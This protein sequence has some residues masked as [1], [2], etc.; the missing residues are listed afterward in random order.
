MSLDASELGNPQITQPGL[1]PEPIALA[2]CRYRRGKWSNHAA[3]R[4]R[5][6]LPA[7]IPNAINAV[8]RPPRPPSTLRECVIG[9]FSVAWALGGAP[10]SP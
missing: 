6:A 1:R 9:R 3:G 7:G 2:H 8:R 5:S 10:S 4:G